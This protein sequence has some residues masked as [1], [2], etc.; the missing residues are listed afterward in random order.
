MVYRLLT[1]VKE[2]PSYEVTRLQNK[3]VTKIRGYKIREVIKLV[4]R[5]GNG[6]LYGWKRDMPLDLYYYL[7]KVAKSLK[8]APPFSHSRI[9]MII[10]VLVENGLLELA[11]ELNETINFRLKNYIL[12]DRLPRVYK[13]SKLRG[14]KDTR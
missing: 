3:Q 13:V 14:Y 7:L 4:K 9:P 12:Y 1:K 6:E 5:D 11:T 2:Q 10:Y 8:N